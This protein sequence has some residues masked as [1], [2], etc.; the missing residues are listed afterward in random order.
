MAR[1]KDTARLSVL[2]QSKS[3]GR[4]YLEEYMPT[5]DFALV[6]VGIHQHVDAII[7]GHAIRAESPPED[8]TLDMIDGEVGQHMFARPKFPFMGLPFSSHFSL[9]SLPSRNSGLIVIGNRIE[10]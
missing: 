3:V 4:L 2:E 1:S 5:F 8:L 9:V 7:R 10:W 6:V